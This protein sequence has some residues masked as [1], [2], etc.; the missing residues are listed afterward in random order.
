MRTRVS[1]VAF[2]F[3]GTLSDD[4]PLLCSI[5]AGLFAEHGRPMSEADYYGT[6][7]GNTEEAI[8][9]GWLGV[10]GE[11]LAGLVEERVARYRA[12][13]A[14]GHTVDAGR[15]EAVRA[16]AERAPVAVVSGAYRAEIEPVL[17]AAGIL[18]LFTT[19]VTADD[20]AA[21][22]PDP[23]SYALLVRRLGDG[24][25]PGEVLAFE[26]TEAGVASAKDAGLRCLAVRGTLPVERLARA[27]GVVDRI[28]AGLLRRLLA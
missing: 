27:D 21:G 15:R 8:I 19:L 25:V 6:L 16:A 4:E 3:N 14:D 23:E 7:A 10:E 5:Y 1:A 12:A 11:V 24:I 22:K 20:V 13:A 9:G 26:D 2:D 17:A 28:D 18:D